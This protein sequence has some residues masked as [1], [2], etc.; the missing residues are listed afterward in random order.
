MKKDTCL[1]SPPL[2]SHLCYYC[3]PQGWVETRVHLLVML[4]E[5]WSWQHCCSVTTQAFLQLANMLRSSVESEWLLPSP[6]LS[7][8]CSPSV[9][10]LDWHSLIKENWKCNLGASRLRKITEGKTWG[11]I[12]MGNKGQYA[13]CIVSTEC[14]SQQLNYDAFDTLFCWHF[15]PN[16]RLQNNNQIDQF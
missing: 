7:L 14:L 15:Q 2:G 11:W 8:I 10:E 6:C 13:F 5:T 12:S 4:R 1:Q 9:A 3:H 16:S